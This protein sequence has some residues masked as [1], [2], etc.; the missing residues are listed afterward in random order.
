MAP[1]GGA[2]ASRALRDAARAARAGSGAARRALAAAAQECTFG[3]AS[4]AAAQATLFAL[5]LASLALKRQ[6]ETPR[7][8][9]TVWSYDV[10]KQG[11]S[12]LAA[13]VSGL[14]WS[15]VLRGPDAS[16]CAFYLVVFTID[17]TLG[18][19]ISLALHRRM[20]AAARNVAQQ[21]PAAAYAGP[22]LERLAPQ[23]APPWPLALARNGEYGEPPNV[24]VWAVQMVG[25][26]AC[27]IVGACLHG[28]VCRA[29]A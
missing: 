5:A 8:S 6:R 19:A 17:T 21:H 23:R 28:S 15:H 4:G 24:R 13:H 2:A 11:L 25:W 27:V 20:L 3:G 7:R 1:A 22:L 12:S 16:E 14:A 18:V 10:S 9:F 29:S 26:C